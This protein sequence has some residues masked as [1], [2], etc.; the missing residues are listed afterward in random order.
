MH[1]AIGDRFHAVLVNNGLLRHNEAEDVYKTLTEQF[2]IQLTVVDASERFLT[3]LK[4]VTEPEQKR[5][6]I[7]KFCLSSSISLE[8]AHSS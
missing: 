6:I 5:K 8:H 7:G 2:G 4:G 1:E 3:E